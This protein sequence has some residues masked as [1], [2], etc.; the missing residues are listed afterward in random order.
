MSNIRTFV[1]DVSSLDLGP[2][3]RMPW[4]PEWGTPMKP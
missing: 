2:E 1:M 4:D 3:R